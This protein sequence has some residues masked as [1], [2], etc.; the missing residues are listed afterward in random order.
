MA[1]EG[2]P[3]PTPEDVESLEKILNTQD[4]SSVEQKELCELLQ[5]DPTLVATGGGDTDCAG[6]RDETYK[7]HRGDS[8]KLPMVQNTHIHKGA[9][10]VMVF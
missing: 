3:L 5:Q 7:Y 1:D 6:W 10:S 4:P 8:T 2:R 9:N